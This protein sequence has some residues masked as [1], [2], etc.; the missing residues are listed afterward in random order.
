MIKVSPLNDVTQ[1]EFEKLFTAYYNELGCEDDCAHLLKEY[2]LPDLLSGLLKI[3]VLQ[4]DEKFAGFVVYQIDEL[5]NDWNFREGWGDIREIY[6]LPPFRRSGLGKFLLFTAEMK[7]REAGASKSY[8][9]PA[10]GSEPF[11]KACGYAETDDY[12]ADLECPVYIKENLKN[13]C[14]NNKT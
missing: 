8:C 6:V 12:N 1:A 9:L 3:D 7:L 5:G 11:F 4:Q 14:A 10:E 13:G 2:V